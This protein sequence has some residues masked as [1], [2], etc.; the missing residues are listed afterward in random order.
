MVP[1]FS[2]GFCEPILWG[3]TQGYTLPE[4]AVGLG[5]ELAT[6]YA[7]VESRSGVR[8]PAIVRHSVFRAPVRRPRPE[9]L[10]RPAL[11]DPERSDA[12]YLAWAR[13]SR[14]A[15]ILRAGVPP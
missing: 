11:I 14:A 2:D 5:L 3:V 10:A 7:V 13:A 4:I 12:R 6:V 1:D 8:F 9:L 15:T